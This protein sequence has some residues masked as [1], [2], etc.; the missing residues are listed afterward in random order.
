MHV[1]LNGVAV[2]AESIFISFVRFNRRVTRDA[3][4]VHKSL[5]QRPDVHPVT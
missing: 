3:T 1:G 2:S 4:Q 5:Q